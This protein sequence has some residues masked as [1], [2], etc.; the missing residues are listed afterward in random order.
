MMDAATSA[1]L[2][3]ILAA[4]L[5][6]PLALALPEADKA[7]A[8]ATARRIARDGMT[9]K[10]ARQVAAALDTDAERKQIS[11][12][13]TTIASDQD[14]RLVLSWILADVTR[15]LAAAPAGGPAT[16]PQVSVHAT[17]FLRNGAKYTSHVLLSEKV[18]DAERAELIAYN[19]A[20]GYGV[21]YVYAANEGD[22]GRRSVAYDHSKRDLWRKWLQAIIDSGARVIMW[23]CADDSNNL[24]KR[25][26]EEWR[27][28]WGLIHADCGDLI[29]EW[30][31]GLECDERWSAS[32]TQSLTRLLKDITG[33]PVGVHTTGLSAVAHAA[34]ADAYYLQAG[35]GKS[36]DQVAALVREAKARFRGRVICAE[37]HLH[38]ESDDAKAIG[39]AA[40]QA[41]ADGVGNGCTA[42]G[43]RA[44]ATRSQSTT[45]TQKKP[46]PTGQPA[47][48][49]LHA[50]AYKVVSIA[51]W[52]E[53]ISLYNV[54]IRNG[55]VTFS[56]DP[57]EW[58]KD[59]QYISMGKAVNGNPWVFAKRDG[60]WQACTWE[61]IGNSTHAKLDDGLMAAF[62]GLRA[63]ERVAICLAG[64]SRDRHRNV[65]ERSNLV[66]ITV[67]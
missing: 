20:Q 19:K 3:R 26:M 1:A 24:S 43:L 41:G 46:T 15:A 42:A 54:T 34:G 7:A 62:G 35:F 38:G 66:W 27:A 6:H 18:P 49:D 64:L 40:I 48:F 5:A 22:Y 9:A 32:T 30:V 37:Y 61:W 17:T 16:T 53:T 21:L 25:T 55:K 2:E 12:V 56:T 65:E 57:Q 8:V 13:L 4:G 10:E 59:W 33:K 67:P 31:T 51:D 36:P 45:P 39:D 63:G 47:D 23:G 58:G 14:A 29:S 11:D 50:V 44:L 28:Y 60:R 52:R